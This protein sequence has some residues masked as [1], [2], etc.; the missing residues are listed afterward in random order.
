MFLRVYSDVKC[1]ELGS[2]SVRVSFTFTVMA[3][4]QCSETHGVGCCCVE[5]HPSSVICCRISLSKRVEYARHTLLPCVYRPT[6]ATINNHLGLYEAKTGLNLHICVKLIRFI[7]VNLQDFMPEMHAWMRLNHVV[8]M[9]R[10]GLPASPRYDVDNVK[11]GA[12][13]VE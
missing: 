11:H 10:W 3:P 9:T 7:G 5:L 1:D 2:T 4:C 8:C 13:I 6:L 12:C